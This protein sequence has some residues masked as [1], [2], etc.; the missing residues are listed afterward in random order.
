MIH[1]CTLYPYYIGKHTETT[2]L[3]Y[4]NYLD[5]VVDV[6]ICHIVTVCIMHK[7]STHVS[8]PIE[9]HLYLLT[10]HFSPRTG[11]NTDAF[12]PYCEYAS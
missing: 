10:L 7:H 3:P 4:I 5:L 2:D 11:H 1:T 6:Y 9:I 12:L 8:I